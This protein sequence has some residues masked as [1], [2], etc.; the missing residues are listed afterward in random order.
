MTETVVRQKPTPRGPRRSNVKS[1]LKAAKAV[2][3]ASVDFGGIV[4]RLTDSP[5]TSPNSEQTEDIKSIL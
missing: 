1:I 3:A 5:P 4:V 2:G